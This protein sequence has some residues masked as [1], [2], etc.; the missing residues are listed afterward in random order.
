MAIFSAIDAKKCAAQLVP[1]EDGAFLLDIEH[2]RIHK[3]NKSAAE[4]WRLLSQG[5][6]EAQIVHVIAQKYSADESQVRA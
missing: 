1:S 3:L 6:T 2:D 5:R 4:I